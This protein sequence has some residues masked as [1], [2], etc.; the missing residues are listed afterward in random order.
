MTSFF[1]ASGIGIQAILALYNEVGTVPAFFI[2]WNSLR[3]TGV[4][5]SL[6]M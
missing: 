2:L 1:D 4:S 6:K 3:I 5:S